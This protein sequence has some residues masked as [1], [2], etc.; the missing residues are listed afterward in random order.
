MKKPPNIVINAET[1]INQLLDLIVG[2]DSVHRDRN[3]CGGVGGCL[4]LM[5]EA[6]AETEIGDLLA[7]IARSGLRLSLAVSA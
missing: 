3:E 5:A 2:H 1:Q 6:E 7:G 4:M